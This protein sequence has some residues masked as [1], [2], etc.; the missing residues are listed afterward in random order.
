MAPYAPL[1]AAGLAIFGLTRWG[2]GS[3]PFWLVLAENFA[4]AAAWTGPARARALETGTGGS[5]ALSADQVT[6][7]V[8]VCIAVVATGALLRLPSRLASAVSKAAAP[9]YCLYLLHVPVA[10]LAIPWLSSIFGVGTVAVIT[11]V[12][13]VAVA[14]AAY[15]FIERP[16]A[17]LLRQALQGGRA[18]SER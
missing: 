2:I 4:F 10:S 17:R 9:T 12:T 15:H 14:V 18:V 11:S 7:S 6:A 8:A 16:G 3:S 13:S 5:F 1:F